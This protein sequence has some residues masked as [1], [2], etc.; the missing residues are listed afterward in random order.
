MYPFLCFDNC[1]KQP[2]SLFSEIAQQADKYLKSLLTAD[3]GCTYDSTIEINLDKV[4]FIDNQVAS[5]CYNC[6]T[7]V[8]SLI[9]LILCCLVD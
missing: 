4:S 9:L 7:L 8:P 5:T 1:C 3:E 2:W 6:F